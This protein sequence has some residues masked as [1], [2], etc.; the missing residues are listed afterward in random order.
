LRS[1]DV[2][3]G[4]TP[5]ALNGLPVIVGTGLAGLACALSLAPQP[6]VVVTKSELGT[7]C[8]SLW[9]QGGIA[10]PL[11]AD[12]SVALHVADTLAAGDGLCVAEAVKRIIAAAP[13][14]IAALEGWGVAF[15]REDGGSYRASLEAAHCR[16]RVLHAGGGD[17]AGRSIM[18][19][20]VARVRATPSIK[21][22]EHTEVVRLITRDGAIRGL[23]ARIEGRPLVI[24]TERV[25]LATGGIG[26]LWPYSTN[27]SGAIGQG[28]A[29]AAI[30]G[31]RIADAEFVQFHPTAVDIGRDP[32]PLAS[33]ALRGDGARLV[34]E[35]GDP[36]VRDDPRGDL[37]PRD[38]VA[39]AVWSHCA[40]GGRVF[41]D[42]RE[43]IGADF[44][45]RFPTLY[46][47][48]I[49]AGIDPVTTPIPV[50]PGAHYHMGGVAVDAAG[51]SNIPGLWA[52]GEAAA[53]GLH[54]ANR[55]ASN[56]L[57]EAVVTGRAVAADL[58]ALAPMRSRPALM[59]VG[60]VDDLSDDAAVTQPVRSI[61]GRHV[62]IL[63]AGEGMALALAQLKPF[64]ESGHK[65]AIAALMITAG[66]Y[67]RC[68][69]RGAQSRSDF[70]QKGP[71]AQRGFMTL[72]HALDLA[73]RCVDDTRIAAGVRP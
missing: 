16:R 20:L 12:D 73:G 8:S 68:E 54:G 58:A 39:R 35:R 17:T 59:P 18:E 33:E 57:L 11:G 37:A 10:A 45:E 56:S 38:V 47:V 32:M 61:M 9:A 51:R 19:A 30:A 13:E 53:T 3:T 41:L 46:G 60:A 28:L 69:S 34:D 21:I 65:A 15:D 6:V 4:L 26:G 24:H 36:I 31:A 43:A 25:V 50:R 48:C 7:G 55:L 5:G 62:G 64:A 52:C 14:A 22:L 71:V 42:G 63:R 49:A 67:L 2:V 23:V 44:P 27:P 1:G 29:L 70:P 40:A 72:S 66:A